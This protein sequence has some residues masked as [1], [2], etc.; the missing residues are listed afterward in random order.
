MS[1]T[2][3]GAGST[4][5]ATLFMTSMSDEIKRTWP[6]AS[7][8]VN[9]A[10][11]L[12]QCNFNRLGEP[13]FGPGECLPPTLDWFGYDYYCPIPG[14]ASPY[15][16]RAG[17]NVLRDGY[18]SMVYPCM[19]RASQRAIPTTI[20][21]FYNNTSHDYAAMDSY[22]VVNARQMLKWALDDERVGGVFPFYWS[23]TSEWI[24]LADLPKCRATWRAIG[25]LVVAAGRPL[26]RGG[27]T[28]GTW[29]DYKCANTKDPVDYDFCHWS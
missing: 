28:P 20:G 17:W 6:E 21:F 18:E 4:C 24:G 26:P 10:Q 2:N 13:F 22:C 1:S 23:S 8:Y 3:D 27:G 9:E 25:E 16:K 11:D 7:V 5:T 14:C 19:T 15:G 29:R 12:A